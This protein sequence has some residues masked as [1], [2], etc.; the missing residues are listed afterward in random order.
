MNNFKNP[1]NI[2]IQPAA[3]SARF[4]CLGRSEG[5]GAGG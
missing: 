4:A 3:P 1:P 2:G 5:V